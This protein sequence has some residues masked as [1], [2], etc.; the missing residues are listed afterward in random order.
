MGQEWAASTPFLFF[1]D[2]EP[3]LGRKVTEGR[4]EEFRAFSAFRDPAARERIP[5]PQ[6]KETFSRSKLDW[7][8]VREERHA[9]VLRLYR[10]LLHLRHAS[11]VLRNRSRD[12]FQILPPLDGIVRLV[13][14]KP[15]G[16]QWL[17]LADLAGGHDMPRLDGKRTWQ[18]VLCSNEARFGGE[19]GPAFAQPEVRVLRSVAALR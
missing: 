13:F 16:E 1:T 5:D 12:N 9:G 4:R 18:R 8:E 19:D 17:V 11:A 10:E 14:G 7:N 6:A 3:E 2:H 15:G